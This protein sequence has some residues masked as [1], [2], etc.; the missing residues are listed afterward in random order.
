MVN[1]NFGFLCSSDQSLAEPVSIDKEYYRVRCPTCGINGKIP[2]QLVA[3]T[4]DIGGIQRKISLRIP[5]LFQADLFSQLGDYE[6][7]EFPFTLKVIE[8]S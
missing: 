6:H 5:D 3:N 2:T 1:T 8:Q 7:S 4:F